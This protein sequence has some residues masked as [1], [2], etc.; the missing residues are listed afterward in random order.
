MS[1]IRNL[2]LDHVAQTSEM[3]MCIEVSHAAGVYIFGQAA[4]SRRVDAAR[5][6]A[7]SRRQRHAKAQS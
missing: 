6:R 2:Y 3:S 7:W 4:S 1:S 5:A